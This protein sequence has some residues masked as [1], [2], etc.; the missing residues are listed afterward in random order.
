MLRAIAR[1]SKP[2]VTCSCIAVMVFSTR[3][4]DSLAFLLRA[5]ESLTP[6]NLC[7]WN[8]TSLVPVDN[9]QEALPRLLRLHIYTSKCASFTF[10]GHILLRRNLKSLQAALSYS[11]PRDIL[12]RRPKISPSGGYGSVNTSTFLE[13]SSLANAFTSQVSAHCYSQRSATGLQMV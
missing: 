1:E 4:L 9:A 13:S 12:P 11:G 3:L 8:N 2:A 5:M 6:D 7:S 10:S